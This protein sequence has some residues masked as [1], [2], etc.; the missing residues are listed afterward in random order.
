MDKVLEVQVKSTDTLRKLYETCDELGILRRYS[1][2]L[3]EVEVCI[4]DKWV[5]FYVDRATLQQDQQDA[6]WQDD[7]ERVA[8]GYW[9]D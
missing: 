2:E 6:Y 4:H 3:A 9:K 1:E 8:E 7:A 5:L